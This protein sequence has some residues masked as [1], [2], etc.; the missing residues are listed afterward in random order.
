[1]RRLVVSLL[2]LLGL[3]FVADRGAVL[4]TQRQLADQ[5]QHQE[6]LTQR[7]TVTLSGF[8]F[9]SQVLRGRYDGADVRLKDLRTGGLPVHQLEV[10]LRG[11]RLPLRDVLTGSIGRVPVAEVRGTARI[12]YADLAAVTGIAGLRIRPQGSRLEL[13]API[14]ELGRTVR[15]VVSA[16]VTVSGQGLKLTAGEVQGQP[17]PQVLVDLALSQLQNALPL[18]RLPYGLRLTGVRVRP[19]GIDVS[20]AASDVVLRRGQPTA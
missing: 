19:A 7:P 18:D 5:I 16:Q 2:V 1:M 4:V 6:A 3:A 20:A 15:L 17:V 12:G 10:K 9:L 11:V 8:P 14:S 13:S